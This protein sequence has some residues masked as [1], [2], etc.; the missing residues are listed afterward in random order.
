MRKKDNQRLEAFEMIIL[1]KDGD[2]QLA[3]TPDNWRAA[4]NGRGKKSLIGITRSWQ[5]NWLGYIMGGSS[6]LRTIIVYCL[7]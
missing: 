5:R 3:V 6:L 1:Q 4:I 7:S 2:S